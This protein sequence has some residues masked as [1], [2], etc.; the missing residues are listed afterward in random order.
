ML[1]VVAYACSLSYLGSIG[2]RIIVRGQLGKSMRPYLKNKKGLRHGSSSRALC[3]EWIMR[4]LHKHSCAQRQAEF[5][6]APAAEESKRGGAA[7]LF[8]LSCLCSEK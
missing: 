7:Q 2:N 1:G 6:T 5:V 4:S 8:F 3:G